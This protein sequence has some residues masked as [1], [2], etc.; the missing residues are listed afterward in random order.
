MTAQVIENNGRREYAVISVAEY[1]ALLDKAEMLDDIKAFDAALVGN[2]ELIPEAVV[3]RLLA[4]ENKI[5]VWREHRKLTQTHGGT[6]RHCPGN[7]RATANGEASINK[8][9]QTGSLKIWPEPIP[10]PLDIDQ[11]A[12][13][14]D[15]ID[16]GLSHPGKFLLIM[17]ERAGRAVARGKGLSMVGTAAI[18]GLAKKQGLIPSARQI[19][20]ELH[21][22]DFRISAAVINRVLSGVNENA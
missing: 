16:L 2:D 10:S 4:G 11:D 6:G 12:G 20:E 19:F 18:I 5:K 13:E 22:S 14:A 17:D 1:E 21:Q 8:S 9:I 7:C 3:Q 15:C